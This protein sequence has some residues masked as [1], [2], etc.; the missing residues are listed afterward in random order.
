MEI[1]RVKAGLLLFSPFMEDIVMNSRPRSN[2]SRAPQVAS[3][4][5]LL[6]VLRKESIYIREDK[7]HHLS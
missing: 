2:T 7:P 3:L 4:R 5:R 6:Q 1:V